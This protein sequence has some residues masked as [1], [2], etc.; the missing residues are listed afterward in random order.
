MT[1]VQSIS[2]VV[3]TCEWNSS[4]GRNRTDHLQLLCSITFEDLGLCSKPESWPPSRKI[5]SLLSEGSLRLHASSNFVEATF[6]EVAPS[7]WTEPQHDPSRHD[8]SFGSLVS[9]PVVSASV[10]H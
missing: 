10:R 9:G 7:R 2:P 1:L 6:E 4:R 8:L 3:L 5:C